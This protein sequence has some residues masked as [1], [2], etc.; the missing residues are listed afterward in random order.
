MKKFYWHIAT[1][2]LMLV[3]MYSIEALLEGIV[4]PAFGYAIGAAFGYVISVSLL[5]AIRN[6]K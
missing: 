2:V 3:I 6:R 4:K 5:N 1:I